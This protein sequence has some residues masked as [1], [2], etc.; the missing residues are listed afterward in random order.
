V[1]LDLPVARRGVGPDGALVDPR[2]DQVDLG[3]RERG[4]LLRHAVLVVL[5]QEQLDQ[6]ALLRVAREDGLAGDAALHR[7]RARVD[8][9]LPLR[10]LG[11]VALE[12]GCLENRLNVANE[13]GLRR[14]WILGKKEQ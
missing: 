6:Q 10:L 12:A 7:Q 3:R 2:S 13:V 8:P 14:R 1:G 4:S 11:P 9:E 5:V